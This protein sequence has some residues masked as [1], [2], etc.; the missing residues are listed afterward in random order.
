VLEA[1]ACGIP[2]VTTRRGALA[3]IVVD[4]E[5]GVLAD[6][7]PESL[8]TAWEGLLADPLRRAALG[9]AASRRAQ[10][11]FAPEKLADAVLRLYGE[12]SSARSKRA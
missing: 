7:T 6:E 8:A 11:L 9:A 5:T 2:A 12:A 1:A 4:G 3:E 10:R